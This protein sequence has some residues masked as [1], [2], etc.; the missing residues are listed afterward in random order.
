[1]INLAIE[2]AFVWSENV[3]RIS[4]HFFS[5]LIDTFSIISF[6]AGSQF[7]F[8]LRNSEVLK[9]DELQRVRLPKGP[10]QR[11]NTGFGL[12]EVRGWIKLKTKNSVR[13]NRPSSS[14]IWDADSSTWKLFFNHLKLA[15][16]ISNAY[17]QLKQPTD[18]AIHFWTHFL[19][20]THFF[21]HCIIFLRSLMGKVRARRR[22]TR[23]L[24]IIRRNSTD[25][26]SPWSFLW[27]YRVIAKCP[28]IRQSKISHTHIS[29]TQ[30]F[31]SIQHKEEKCFFLLILLTVS[32]NSTEK[33]SS[34]DNL[35]LLK[36]G[37][38]LETHLTFSAA[39]SSA[40]NLA[41]TSRM[42]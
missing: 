13:I 16:T 14:T 20:Y 21:S 38:D 39:R 27:N 25:F 26:W 15:S 12:A 9:N 36:K 3:F 17:A 41:K 37:L 35:W 1:M 7:F 34:I 11:W 30:N 24:F 8:M 19:F 22:K 31:T 4:F 33:A 10:F 2:D 40:E 6:H 5:F 42:H 32:F 23:K 29:R 18:N 28:W